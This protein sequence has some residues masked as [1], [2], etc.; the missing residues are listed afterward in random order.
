VTGSFVS[1]ETRQRLRDLAQP[2]ATALGRVGLT[3]NALTI[4]GFAG[5]CVAAFG[6]ATQSW[7]LAGILV[8]VFGAF[9]LLDGALARATGRTS[10]FGAFLDSTLDRTGE[11]LVYAGVAVGSYSG[12]FAEGVLLAGLAATFASGVTYARAKAESLG[13]RGDVGYAP[14]EVRLLLLGIGLIATQ[15][16]GGLACQGSAS[17]FPRTSAQPGGGFALEASLAVITVLSAVT[18]I[19]RI[20]HVR[21]QSREG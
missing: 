19:Q 6:A 14:R 10:T 11:S 18:V 5:T 1:P 7:L 20:V 12:A 17:C 3:P 13:L 2:I 9:D 21:A 4:I 16:A 15:V 8:L